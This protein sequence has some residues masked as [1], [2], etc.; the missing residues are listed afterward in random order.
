MIERLLA[1]E[2]AFADGQLETAERLYEQVA[3]ADPRNAIALV[4]LARVAH[5]RGSEAA[6]RDLAERALEIDPEEVAATRLLVELTTEPVPEPEPV[7]PGP[8]AVREPAPT[9][10]PGL[11]ERLRAWL[12]GRLGRRA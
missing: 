8:V 9:A 11:L 6:A 2:A 7:P 12:R 1:A 4:G 3:A 5:R 10:P